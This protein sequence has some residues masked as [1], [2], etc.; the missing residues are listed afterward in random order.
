M[1]NLKMMVCLLTSSK[2]EYLKESLKSVK[3][4]Q[5]INSIDWDIFIIVNTLNDEYYNKLLNEYPEENIVRTESNGKPGKG[6]NSV[7][8]FFKKKEEYSYLFMLD[9]DDFLY[10]SALRHIESYIASDNPEILMLMYHDTL[11]DILRIKNT[12]H[13]V[14]NNKAYL[15]YNIHEISFKNWHTDKGKNPFQNPI[16]QM[17]SMG[18]LILFSRESIKYNIRYDEECVLYDDFYPTM[19]VLEL[20]Y[21]NKNIIK[22]NDSNIYLYNRINDSSVT[23]KWSKNFFKSENTIF[24]KSIKNKFQLIQDW[25]L[26]K[27]TYKIIQNDPYFTF[28]DKYKFITKIVK[29][30][31]ID[32]YIDEN[33]NDYKIFIKYIQE[34]KIEKNHKFLM[35]YYQ[36]NYK[37][38]LDKRNENKKLIAIYIG[39]TPKFNGL[40]YHTVE[41]IAGTEI[42]AIKLAEELGKNHTVIIF[43]YN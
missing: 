19:Q 28:E 32:N 8:D 27:I 39:Y 15:L 22:T 3:N 21:L 41:G 36:N 31:T 20:A 40:N 14:I 34:Q 1:S 17:N 29:N 43:V 2:L 37:E 38:V 23:K 16:F 26:K 33:F 6:H 25:N 35:K 4:Q 18:R 5:K 13:M 10:P 30:L 9:G 42:S 11:S 7:L 12:T 24:K